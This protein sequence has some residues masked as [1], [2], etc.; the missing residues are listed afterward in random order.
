MC[1]ARCVLTGWGK[2]ELASCWSSPR[3]STRPPDLSH[4]EIVAASLASCG[5]PPGPTTSTMSL[6]NLPDWYGI[7][8]IPA[9]SRWLAHDGSPTYATD[10]RG[11]DCHPRT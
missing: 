10:R 7:V 1:S 11:V 5:P 4:S 8:E 3:A 2:K 9:Y 6:V